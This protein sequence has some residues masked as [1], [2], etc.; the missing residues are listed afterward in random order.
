MV[1]LSLFGILIDAMHGLDVDAVAFILVLMD[2]PDVVL[3]GFR[4]LEMGEFVACS[5]DSM[6]CLLHDLHHLDDSRRDDG[7]VMHVDALQH[8]VKLVDD[9]VELVSEFEDIFA[10]DGRDEFDDE[11]FGDFL[12]DAVGLLLDIMQDLIAIENLIRTDEAQT[13]LF[14]VMPHQIIGK[15]I[16]ILNR[17]VADLHERIEVVKPV[18][19]RHRSTFLGL[20]EH[21]VP[22][23]NRGIKWSLAG[24]WQ[25]RTTRC[26]IGVRQMDR[27]FVS[28]GDV[29]LTRY[30]DDMT[31][32][33]VDILHRPWSGR[34]ILLVDLD[35]FFASVEQ[36]DHPEWRGKP[37]IVGGRADRRGVVS[38]CSYEAR[39]YG[40]RSA[41]ASATAERLCPDAIWTTPHFERY[42]ELSK[43]IM[44]ILYAESP[45]LQ[46]VSIDEAF[47]DVTPGRFTGDD[48]VAIA[49][50]I[51]EHVAELGVTCSIG[52]ATNK[53]VAKIASDL[54]KPQGLTVVYPGS[55]ATFLAPLKI[56]AMSG[57]GKQSAKRLENMGIRTLGDLAAA[58]VE[59]LRPVFGVNAQVMHD[60]ALGIDERAIVTERVLKSVSHERTFA[61]DLTTRG[62]IEDAIDF[63]GSLV[64]RRLRR[65]HLSGHTVTLKLRYNDLSIRSAQHSL[66]TNVDDES[67][68]IPVAKKLVGEIWQQGDAV[69][70]VGVG[71]SGFDAQDEQLDLF[72]SVKQEVGNTE[73]IAAA[74]KVRDKF[75]D[76]MLKFGRELKLKAKDTGTRGMNDGEL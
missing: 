36:L 75:G 52:V 3:D 73:V 6:R 25:T 12:D 29:G 53:T 35:A 24:F 38:T 23:E 13:F 16:G 70:L 69:R 42:H 60:R 68:F 10:L 40:V 66:G 76:G 20:R 27:S 2:C 15:L 56:R 43:A 44:D 31:P 45:L 48:P 32:R 54:D 49:S 33:Q 46:Q 67:I 18:L 5:L 4:L 51:Q 72:A 26:A 74:D 65:K 8:I 37:L 41:M 21:I 55:E 22:D 19:V 71:I 62:E 50:R 11:V 34:A 57:I 9:R 14:V 63:L 64:G 1:E 47:L 58:D 7:D 61:N 17:I 28:H 59:N 30:N 39:A